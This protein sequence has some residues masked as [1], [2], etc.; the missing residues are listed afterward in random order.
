[1]KIFIADD[2]ALIRKSLADVLTD[3]T[4]VEIV[5]QASRVDEAVQGIVKTAPKLVILDI[6]MPPTSGIDV[7]SN[8]KTKANPPIVAVFTE[9]D[10]PEYRLKCRQAGADFFFVKSSEQDELIE[11]IR[12]LAAG[13][14]R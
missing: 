6:H 2:S 1:M 13:E 9:Y 8:V 14:N 11:L 4:D 12:R 10:F 3:I 5:G 7:L